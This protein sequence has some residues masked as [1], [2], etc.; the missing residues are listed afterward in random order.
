M[1]VAPA[2]IIPR[3]RAAAPSDVVDAAGSRRSIRPRMVLPSRLL[4][5][6]CQLLLL[7]LDA[8]TTVARSVS[9]TC[10]TEGAEWQDRPLLLAAPRD[11]CTPL[12]TDCWGHDLQRHTGVPSAAACCALCKSTSGCGAWTYDTTSSHPALCFV[13]SSCSQCQGSQCSA[14]VTVVSGSSGRPAPAPPPPPPPPAP[15][16][17]ATLHITVNTSAS[18]QTIQGFGGCFNEKGWDALSSLPEAKRTT[19]LAAL[20]SDDGLRYGINRMPIGSSDFADGY[21]SL[22]DSPGDY[23]MSNLSLARD[24][25][26]LLPYIKAAMK[27][28][29]ELKVWGSPWTAPEWL[30][31]SAPQA[32][33]NEGC[34]SLST[35]PKKRAAYALYLAKVAKAYRAEGLAFE[36]LAI[37]NEPNQGGTW[38]PVK[39]QCGDS[40]P[41]MHWSKPRRRTYHVPVPCIE[42][43]DLQ[44]RPS[45]ISCF[46]CGSTDGKIACALIRDTKLNVW[47]SRS[48]ACRVCARPSWPDV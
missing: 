6:L 16:A 46:L 5:L 13:K 41:K 21:Y 10:S 44:L 24:R 11:I 38:D 22:D 30:K 4:L 40:Y 2:G 18:F 43:V 12:T 48:A 27:V 9:W 8:A 15:V 31:D 3:A 29:P 33:K 28:R 37:Q 32:P 1:L 45:T 20:F 26:K 23:S 36:H 19:V 35:D 34:G 17:N 25:A 47:Y 39:Q 7:P 14:N 42:R